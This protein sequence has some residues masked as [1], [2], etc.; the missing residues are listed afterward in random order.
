V[1]RD[2]RRAYG[3]REVVARRLARRPRGEIFGL[4]GRTGGKTT[5]CHDLDAHPPDRGRRL[6]ARQARQ[7]MTSTRRGGCSTVAPQ[8]EAI[9]RTSRRRRTSPSSAELYGVPRP[10]RARFVRE[11]L[12]VV[13]LT[14][15]GTTASRP[16]RRD[17]PA[18]QPRLA[19]VSG[20]RASSSSTSRRSRSIAVARAHLRRVRRLRTAGTTILYTTHYSREAE[21]LCDRIAIMD[22]GRVVRSARCP[23]CSRSR[24]EPR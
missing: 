2:L 7:C 16:L 3:D 22:E 19:L 11:A 1:L 20:S 14:D 4:L 23:S 6:G 15:E 13:G 18:A 8:E 10:E 12:E 5:C 21:N 17:A 9:S 24:T